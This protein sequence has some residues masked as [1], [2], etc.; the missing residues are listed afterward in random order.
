MKDH[1]LSVICVSL[2]IKPP[3]GVVVGSISTFTL[4]LPCYAGS[5][6]RSCYMHLILRL[7]L[8]F[9]D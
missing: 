2:S 3:L 4:F 9:A 1:L 5:V 6:Y 8:V 7:I